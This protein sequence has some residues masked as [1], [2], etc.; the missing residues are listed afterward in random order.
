MKQKQYLV[1]DGDTLS[2]EGLHQIVRQVNADSNIISSGS[3]HKAFRQIIN[4]ELI[5]HV[6]IKNDDIDVAIDVLLF[7]LTNKLKNAS[8]MVLTANDTPAFV[9]NLLSSGA[10][11]VVSS[12][13]SHDII[14]NEIRKQDRRFPRDLRQ[15]SIRADNLSELTARQKQV[16]SHIIQGQANK[17]IA[18]ELGISEGTIKLHV[19]SILRALN[20]TNRTQA[21]IKYRQLFEIGGDY[22]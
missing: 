7:K 14:V 16:M 1:L 17:H 4:P 8:F 21:A 22:A 15:E 13:Q 11:S 18:W 19:S 6:I 20:A 10:N 2:R 9:Q 5:D 12:K 3:L